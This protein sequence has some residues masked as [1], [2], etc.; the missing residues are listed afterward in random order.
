MIQMSCE[1]RVWRK[2]ELQEEGFPVARVSDHLEDP[3]SIVWVDLCR[4]DA[5]DLDELAERARPARARGRGR[6]AEHQRP[7][8][9]RY[10]THLF[11]STHAMSFDP[12]A[13]ELGTIEIDCF[14]GK[15]WL[16][17]VRKDE[18]FSL[19]PLKRQ[20]DQS[21]DLVQLRGQR[22]AVRAPRHRR[23]RLLRRRSRGS[24][25]STTV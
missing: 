5:D 14:I 2:G 21:P 9:D 18:G 6:V 8:L 16:I 20:W 24:T 17:T 3:D 1:T 23:R 19:D 12:E 11:L 7:K 10:E 22:A 4:P 13:A 25:S 15:Q